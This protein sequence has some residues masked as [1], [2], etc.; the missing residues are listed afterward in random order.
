[1]P[2]CSF[3]DTHGCFISIMTG[4]ACPQRVDE[5]RSNEVIELEADDYLD[6]SHDQLF[7]NVVVVCQFVNVVPTK[8][9]LTSDLLRRDWPIRQCED[10]WAYNR[11]GLRKGFG[12]SRQHRSSDWAYRLSRAHD[13]YPPWANIT[14]RAVSNGV[15]LQRHPSWRESTFSINS[16]DKLSANFATKKFCCAAEWTRPESLI[17]AVNQLD[18][19][20]SWPIN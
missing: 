6:H 3:T 18:S 2:A 11:R 12:H 16:D 5:S 14:I 9:L 1:M 4:V 20:R 10:R 19:N 17:T 7:T 15:H 8:R 13:A